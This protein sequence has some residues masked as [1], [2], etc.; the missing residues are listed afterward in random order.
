MKLSVSSNRVRI[1][2]IAGFMVVT[3]TTLLNLLGRYLD[4]LPES[5]DLRH[6]V[7]LFIDPI[8]NPLGA[9]IFGILMHLIEGTVIGIAYVYLIKSPGLMSGV[10]FMLSIWLFL[11]LVGMPISGRGLFG[12][13]EGF[14]M[15]AATLSLHLIFGAAMGLVSRKLSQNN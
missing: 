5:M 1:G 10:L 15:P 14:I 3:G 6:M 4:V 8:H 9:L 11:M 2:A 7:E 12:L 13:S